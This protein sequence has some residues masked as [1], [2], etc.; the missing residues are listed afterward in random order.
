[1]LGA[2]IVSLTAMTREGTRLQA[3]QVTSLNLAAIIAPSVVG[4]VLLAGI[5]A[6]L[7]LLLRRK[8]RQSRA[9]SKDSLL[10]VSDKG[11]GFT[12]GGSGSPG[13][14]YDGADEPLSRATPGNLPGPF[15]LVRLQLCPLI[16][17]AIRALQTAALTREQ[18]ASSSS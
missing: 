6:G 14:P 11:G 16:S 8:H 13:P 5:A 12:A 3:Q 17:V 15:R 1:M 7:V 2:Q 10:P 4:G 9:S 18:A